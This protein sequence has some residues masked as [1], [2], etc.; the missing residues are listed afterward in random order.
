MQAQEQQ[1]RESQ[2]K[3]TS[4]RAERER[5]SGEMPPRG[6]GPTQEG[7]WRGQ[8]AGPRHLAFWLGGGPPGQPQA[9]SG[10]FLPGNF[11]NNFFL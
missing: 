2:R 10:V 4:F 6:M 11:E 7:G 3:N 8:G 1:E 5:M 9:P